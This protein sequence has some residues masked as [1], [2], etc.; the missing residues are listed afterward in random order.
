MKKILISGASS[1]IGRG[2]T[3]ALLKADY[4][5][6]G[7][8]RDHLKF[9]PP[10][11]NYFPYAMDFS[12][13]LQLEPS[14]Q[15]LKKSHKDVEIV[16]C[17]AGYG[18]FGEI[19]QFSVAQLQNMLHVN[20]LSQ[21]ILIKTFL[22][23]LKRK[24]KG[25][26]IVLGSECALE[27]SKKAAMY[28]ATKFALRGFCQSLRQECRTAG[29][30]VTL[31]NPG[32]VKTPFFKKLNFEPTDEKNSSLKVEDVVNCLLLTI[33]TPDN[34]V[35]EEINLQPLRARVRQKSSK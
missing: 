9:N 10:N 3:E 2:L 23:L 12:N 13:I 24:Q 20:F 8:A 28:C 34:C 29:V 16:V 25:K 32:L 31:I 19:E 33:Q 1:G 17:C 27:G 7:L 11:A 35:V 22:P 21:I 26:I 4:K 15:T 5:V 30:G 18:Q 14:L 6:I